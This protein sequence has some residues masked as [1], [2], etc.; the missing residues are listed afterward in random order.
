MSLTLVQRGK[1][2]RRGYLKCKYEYSLTEFTKYCGKAT[3]MQAYV[4]V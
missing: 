4:L 3:N 2:Q 1:K